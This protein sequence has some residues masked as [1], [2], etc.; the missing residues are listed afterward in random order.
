MPECAVCGEDVPR[1]ESVVPFRSHDRTMALVHRGCEEGD[2]LPF[3]LREGGVKRAT[4]V[5]EDCTDDV[6]VRH[7]EVTGAH[8]ERDTRKQFRCP[9]CAAWAPLDDG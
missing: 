5:C 9:R 2:K 7:V 6:S 3:L 8:R 1:R 4:H